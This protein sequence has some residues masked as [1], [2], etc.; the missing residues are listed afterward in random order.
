MTNHPAGVA[1]VPDTGASI[2]FEPWSSAFVEDPYPTYARLREAAPVHWNE[3]L[4]AWFV[5]RY[6]DCARVL[7]DHE[8]FSSDYREHGGDASPQSTCIQSLEPPAH[9]PLRRLLADGFGTVVDKEFAGRVRQAA[10]DAIDAVA[11]REVDAVTELFLP[12]STTTALELLGVTVERDRLGEISE[13]VVRSM[14]A[15]VD[16][17]AAQPGMDARQLMAEIL[18]EQFDGGEFA[19]TGLLARVRADPRLDAVERRHLINS[20]RVVLLAGINSTHR[21]LANSLLVLLTHPEGLR[22][23]PAEGNTTRALH[24]LARFDGPFQAQEKM[25]RADVTLGG[26]RLRRGDYVV[27]LVGAANRDGS[28]FAEP[29]HLV[30]S[31]AKN[32]HLGFGVGHHSCLGAP[33]ALILGRALLSGLRGRSPDAALAGNPVREPNPTLRGLLSLPVG[34]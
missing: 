18:E 1:P 8:V 26:A 29:D 19:P 4:Q 13:A 28:T 31:R 25:V 30:L 20:F 24:E 16:E 6:A 7:T 21:Y 10:D 32:P 17:D 14:M 15:K 5:S 22:L 3:R 23:F 34:F 9:I 11:G 27:A 12:L 33:L 2:S